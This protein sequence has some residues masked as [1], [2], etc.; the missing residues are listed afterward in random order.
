MVQMNLYAK[1]KQSHR[2]RKEKNIKK[3]KKTTVTK[4]EQGRDNLG[5]W[6]FHIHSTI[7]KIDN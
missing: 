3:K 7:C 1:W 2:Y 6:D 5:D 4:E